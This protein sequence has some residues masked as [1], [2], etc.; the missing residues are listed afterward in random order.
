MMVCPVEVHVEQTDD[1]GDDDDE[2]NEDSSHRPVSIAIHAEQ[3]D[4]GG[5]QEFHL[6]VD[7]ESFP[8]ADVDD[9]RSSTSYQVTTDPS[10]TK[11]LLTTISCDPLMIM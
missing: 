7:R 8:T 6:E 5:M 9:V 2:K 3:K 1:E 10:Q 11:V 4:G